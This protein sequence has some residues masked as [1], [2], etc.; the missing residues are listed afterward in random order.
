MPDKDALTSPRPLLA[1]F[2]LSF[3]LAWG[4]WFALGALFERPPTGLV[5]LGAWAPTL[6]ALLVTA[7]AEGRGGVARLLRR[8]LRWRVAPLWY[9][10]AVSGAS[11]LALLAIG[12]TALLGGAVPTLGAVAA[13]FGLS[14]EH[15]P[16][17]FA[18]LPLIFL[19]TIF[20]GGPVAEELGWR[21]YAQT[22]LRAYLSPLEAGLLLGLIWALWHLPL[23]LVLPAAISHVPLL[24]YLPLVTA[25]GGLFGL[26]HA[27]TGGS[28]LLSILAHAGVNLAL[29]A[30]GLVTASAQLLATFVALVWLALLALAVLEARRLYRR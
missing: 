24:A 2:L 15:A 17:L 22:K 12:L 27:H 5:V 16:R 21:G 4:V 19:V 26:L 28:V 20:S 13:R 14:A 25:L 7:R 11:L 18:L 30:L 1:F 10:L 29:G 9:L 23:F 8:A 3:A 6:A